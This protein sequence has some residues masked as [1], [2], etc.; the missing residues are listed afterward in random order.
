MEIQKAKKQKKEVEEEDMRVT[1][2]EIW[3]PKKY[4]RENLAESNVPTNVAYWEMEKLEMN[5]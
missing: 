4:N 3:N 2:K 5:W 1:E